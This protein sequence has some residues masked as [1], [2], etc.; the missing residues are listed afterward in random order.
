MAL[1]I[2]SRLRSIAIMIEV[3]S[4]RM[5]CNHFNLDYSLMP[6][7]ALHEHFAGKCIYT[8]SAY[9]NKEKTTLSHLKQCFSWEARSK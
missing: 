6:A 3:T 9:L 1:Y 4:H 2:D 7:D 5:E 8:A